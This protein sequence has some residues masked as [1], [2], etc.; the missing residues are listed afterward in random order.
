M[1]EPAGTASTDGV[2]PDAFRAL[3]AR[4]ASG[5]SVVTARDGAEDAGLTVNALLS[6]SLHPP[7]L[8]ISL[9]H[10]AD[11]TPVILRTRRFAVNILSSEQRSWSDRFAQA[12]PRGEK[13]AGVPVHRVDDGPA[14]LDGALGVFECALV[15]THV[16]SDH[17]LFLGR[18]VAV[19]SGP[20][21]L[22]LVFFRSRY[23]EAAGTDSLTLPPGRR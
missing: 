12:I 10:D 18:V 5:V 1:S 20:D 6:V 9:T 23:G 16:F 4:W 21:A 3:I 11:A 19:E 22:P 14:R 15:E 13:F 17:H 8:L 2:A 7:T